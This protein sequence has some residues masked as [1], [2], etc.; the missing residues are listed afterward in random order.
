MLEDMI[1]RA[2]EVQA[3]AHAPYSRF[4]VGACLRTEDDQLITGCNV[5]NAAYGS[6]ICAEATAITRMVAAGL[7]PKIKEIVVTPCPP[8]GNCRQMLREFCDDDA[9]IHV[10]NDNDEVTTLKLIDYLPNSFVAEHF[11]KE[12]AE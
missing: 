11:V 5:E 6:T 8:C 10:V 12:T 9:L 4:H 3:N 2:R 1:K 7:T